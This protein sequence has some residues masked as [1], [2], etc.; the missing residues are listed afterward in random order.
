MYSRY[1]TTVDSKQKGSFRSSTLEVVIVAFWETFGALPEHR[2]HPVVILVVRW[3]GGEV[4][5]A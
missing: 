1:S 2:L 5:V 4:M 3:F